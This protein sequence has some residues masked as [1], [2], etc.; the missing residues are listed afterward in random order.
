MKSAKYLRLLVAGTVGGITTTSAAIFDE[1]A[2][3]TVQLMPAPTVAVS[4]APSVFSSSVSFR[5]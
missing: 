3:E 5:V 4:T 1:A 2:P